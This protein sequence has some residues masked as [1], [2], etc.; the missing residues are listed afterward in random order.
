MPWTRRRAKTT[1]AATGR[2]PRAAPRRSGS[3]ARRPSRARRRPAASRAPATRRSPR[4]SPAP[5]RGCPA[6]APPRRSASPAAE[7]IVVSGSRPAQM[8]AMATASASASTSA[9]AAAA[10][11]SGGRSAARRRP[12]PAGRARAG[13]PRRASRGSRSGGGR[14]RRRP[15][16]RRPRP[17]ARAGGRRPRTTRGRRRSGPASRPSRAAAAATPSAFATLWAPGRR[18]PDGQRT[19]Q[20]V[21][22]GDLDRRAVGLRGDDPAEQDAGRPGRRRE[23]LGDAADEAAE[24]LAARRRRRPPRDR[25]GPV[26]EPRRRA[27]RRPGR[28]RWR[29]RPA[30]RPPRP[31]CI[32]RIQRL[33]R[34]EHRRLVGEHV[35]VVPLGRGQ[36]RDRRPVRVEVAGV[37]VG[38]DDER[39]RPAGPGAPSPAVPPATRSSAPTNADGSRPAAASTWTSQP[40][41][42]LLPCVP[43]TATRRRPTPRRRRPAATARAG[44]RDARAASSSGWSGSI[45]VSALVTASRSGGGAAVTCAASCSQASG[46]PSSASA[47]VY[48]D[49]PPGS[50]PLAAAP[51]HAREDAPRRSPRRL[52][53][54]RR[55]SARPAGSAAGIAGGAEAGADRGGA[56]HAPRPRGPP[57]RPRLDP[58]EQQLEDGG[59]ARPL[60]AA[61]S[62]DH[63]YRRTSTPSSSATA[64]YVSPTGF[65]SRAAVRAG[66]AGHRRRQ[67]AP[68]RSRAPSAI[69][70][71]TWALTAPWAREDRR[72]HA[73][74]LLLRLVRVGDD[75]AREVAAG[76][77]DLGDRVGDE[78][79]RARLRQ[80]DASGRRPRQTPWSR[81]ASPTSGSPATLPGAGSSSARPGGWNS[82]VSGVPRFPSAPIDWPLSVKNVAPDEPVRTSIDELAVNVRTL[83][84]LAVTP[85][86]SGCELAVDPDL[87]PGRAALDLDDEVH[88]PVRD[89]DVAGDRGGLARGAGRGDRRSPSGRSSGR[90]AC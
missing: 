20:V 6:A 72:R 51:A 80:R 65:A 87:E 12:R 84:F 54:R 82:H 2:A 19:A 86:Q 69:A 52:P 44:C 35:G 61:R 90:A 9:K 30:A 53:R 29:R 33:E 21:E 41:V 62:P 74:Q 18:Q 26:P 49:G 83:P 14:S 23:P 40:A 7:A 36:D 60:F 10:P 81:S 13:G 46:M 38:L 75:A 47:A 70:R 8:S 68:N 37:L 42:V 64:T 89:G 43:A 4:P 58:L 16:R 31:G 63:R 25:A 1:Q 77:G 39:A 5:R 85:A 57:A 15:R 78:P 24:P 71:A 76:A 50:Q 17:C 34:V 27:G 73:E 32:A 56:G 28:R 67:A 45:A 88:A 48:G 22:A 59:R 55:G 66:D 79:A 11:R 3:S